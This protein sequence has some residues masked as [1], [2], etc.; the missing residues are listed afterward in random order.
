MLTKGTRPP[1][2]KAKNCIIHGS[3]SNIFAWVSLT[4]KSHRNNITI[5]CGTC[6]HRG[7]HYRK[8]TQTQ[9]T[10]TQQVMNKP[11]TFLSSWGRTELH[12]SHIIVTLTRLVTYMPSYGTARYQE[13]DKPCNIRALSKDMQASSEPM[14][15]CL[16]KSHIQLPARAPSVHGY[17][18]L[19]PL[20]SYQ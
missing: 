11:V 9:G 20:L 2:S 4:F 16:P 10:K 5:P 1:G 19:S 12:S 18:H 13:A 14:M 8:R 7:L 17:G 6:I 15:A 3:A